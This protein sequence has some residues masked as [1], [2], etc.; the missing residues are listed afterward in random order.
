M[1]AAVIEREPALVARAEPAPATDHSARWCWGLIALTLLAWTA[2]LSSIRSAPPSQYGLLY[3]A[4]PLFLSSMLLNVVAFIACVRSRNFRA[5]LTALVL[6]ALTQRL[7]TTISTDV[8][9]YS[10]TYKHLG[11]VDYIRQSGQLAHGLDVYQGWPGLFALTAWFSDITGVDPVTIAHLFTPAVHL[12]LL[13]LVYAVARTWGLDTWGSL[14]ATFLVESL[15]WVA[16]DYYSPQATALVLAAGFLIVVG[17]SRERATATPLALT[18]FA[19]IVVTHQ[20]TPY[21]LMVACVGL[22]ITRRLKPRWL[23]LAMI[24]MSGAYLAFNYDSVSHFSLLSFNPVSNAKSNVPTIGVLGQRV[25]SK[26]V[27][28]LSL[29]LWASAAVCALAQWWRAR[30][31]AAAPPTARPPGPLARCWPSVASPSVPSYCSAARG[32]A[33][34]RSSGCSSTR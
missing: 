33:A 20:L 26:I 27:R 7:A 25:T 21:W 29:L 9:L 5:G 24:A 28:A 1:S 22:T 34:R 15:N 3:T 14:V 13:G 30:V 18:L 31:C 11:V 2:S 23:I 17:L 32:M 8:P 16:Q 12:A 6:M 19:A 10:W 4:S